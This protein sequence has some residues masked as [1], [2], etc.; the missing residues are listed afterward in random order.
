MPSI[1]RIFLFLLIAIPFRA[2]AE[3]QQ[4]QLEWVY[5]ELPLQFRLFEASTN[6]PFKIGEMGTFTKIDELPALREIKDQAF[7]VPIGG[8]ILLYLTAENKTDREISFAVA[9]HETNPIE[10]SLGFIFRCLCNGHVYK[11]P[12]GKSWYRLMELKSTGTQKTTSP[13]YL[14]HTAFA[15]KGT[16]K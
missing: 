5:K 8:R 6:R 9:P 10:F 12:P 14:K 4:I 7:A 3:T 11:I 13:I 15:V 1:N 16:A 2:F